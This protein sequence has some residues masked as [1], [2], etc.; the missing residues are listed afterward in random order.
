M[1]TPRRSAT[2]ISVS[3]GNAST[4]S[5][6]SLKAMISCARAVSG[7]FMRL[8][9]SRAGKY[10]TTQAIGLGAACPSPQIDAS[11]IACDRSASSGLSQRG[12]RISATAFSVPTRH[13]VHWPHDSSAKNSIMFSAAS[14]AR[15]W[16]DRMITAAEPMKQPCGCSVSKSS[17]MSPIDAG[18]MPPDAPPGR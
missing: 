1:A 16:C 5:P 7:A 3:P 18:R 14:R 9:D 17:G 4:S 12:S 10:F 8:F 13:G 11:I 6:F 15:S 2:S